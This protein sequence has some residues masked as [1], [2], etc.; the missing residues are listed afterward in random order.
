MVNIIIVDKMSPS[1]NL[2][3]ISEGG[4]GKVYKAFSDTAAVAIK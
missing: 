1:E 3:L 2:T 4:Y